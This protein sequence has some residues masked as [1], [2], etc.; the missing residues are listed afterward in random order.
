MGLADNFFA[1]GGHSLLA[2]Q[3]I[4]RV[5]RQLS[6]D[7]ALRAL[8]D[9]PE[10]GAFCAIAAA[11]CEQAE[12]AITLRDRA[13][14][15]PLSHAQQ[16][17]W[18]FWKI[19]PAS[20]AY[21]TPLAVRLNGALDLP[22]LQAAL[23][24]LLERHETLRSVFEEHDGTALQRVLPASGLPVV[25]EDWRACDQAGLEAYL[26]ECVEAPFDLRHG[27]LIRARL[28]RLGEA[29]HV[30]LLTLHHI[31]SDGWSMGVM[32]RECLAHYNAHREGTPI[33]IQPLAVQYADYASWQRERL[34]S[35]RQQAQIDYWKARL[36][37]DFSVLE[38]PA[39][40]LRPNVPSHRGARLDIRLPEH[41]TE[42]L[43]ALAVGANATLF[44]VFLAT[45]ALLLA[46]SSGRE[47]IN[48]GVPMTNRDRV[49]LE[50]LIGFFVN[51]VVVRTAVDPSC[52]FLDLL[53]Q[54]RDS[55]LGAQAHNDLPFDAL[56]EALQPQRS[57]SYNPLFQV[58]YNHLRDVGHKVDGSSAAGL[59]VTEL[60]LSEHT[61]QFDLSLNTLERSDG[62]LASFNYATD[63]FEASRIEALASQWLRVLEGIARSPSGA[64]GELEL[65]G[66][67]ALQQDARALNPAP[68]E[69]P[70]VAAHRQFEA[71]V[72]EAP[73]A[74]AL[75]VGTRSLTYSQ[76]NAH[77][78]RLAR[79]LIEHGIGPGQ[80]V[81]V[82]LPRDEHLVATL[83]AVFK[84][85]G[86][87]VPLDLAYPAERVAYMLEDSR[88]QV[89]V[90][91]S[92]ARAQLPRLASVQVLALDTLN[93]DGIAPHNLADSVAPAALAYCIYTSGSTG[94]PKGVM[95]EQRNLSALIGWAATV[96]DREQ[97]QGVLASTSICFDLSVWELFVTLALGGQV[98]LAENALQLPQLPARDQVRLINTVPSAIK[99]LLDARQ[100]PESIRTI[101]LAGEPLKQ[102]LVDALYAGTQAE[103]LYDLYG[104]S[105]D[106]TYS[107]FT[108]RTA[109][110]R[111]TI[112]RP[113]AGSWVH[114]LD[115]AGQR[116]AAGS[117]AE[118]CIGGVGLSR[119]YLG[120]P[121]LT[122]EKFLPDPFGPAPGQ[123]MY[124]TGDLARQDMAGELVYEGRIDHQV[125]V[126]GFRI[127]LGEIETRLQAFDGIAQ[128]V[129]LAVDG[130][131]VAYV[132]PT[133]EVAEATLRN[134][135]RAYLKGSLP[136]Y[137]VPAHFVVLSAL[138]LTPNGKLDRKALPA[139]QVQA[140]AEYLPPQTDIE[141]RL[142][143]FWAQ[144]LGVTRVGLTDNFFEL[145][146]HSLLATQVN[147]QAQAEYAI[148]LPLIELFQA[149]TLAA[150][151]QSV[152]ARIP[153]DTQDLDELRDFLTDLETV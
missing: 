37:D 152:A 106:T 6:L 76:L 24:A 119:G 27:P 31:V 96:Y 145:G 4:S 48:L 54:V 147:A 129:V 61:A 15:L 146:G 139:P 34:A 25:D 125:K 72:A 2:T 133:A 57:T 128:A 101:N 32:V 148:D 121:A 38:L 85:G 42:R 84:A 91:T 26:R 142:A 107:T 97:L 87:Y 149:P 116:V 50:G 69:Y 81:A 52:S 73:D 39:D 19:H 79:V 33:A 78:N 10:L 51:T 53:A 83:L 140:E 21:H 124:R 153:G 100:L 114:L 28:I 109:G 44:H 29:E 90:T 14:A 131:L 74:V 111:A 66:E 94:K 144:V 45:F 8:F 11:Q 80:K 5:R 60:E 46:R 112:G 17:Q 93:L 105:E 135:L 49:E 1:L 36:E 132:V 143:E 30:L 59:S 118:I 134:A 12:A 75:I 86:A 117:L 20:A 130:Q 64:V 77:A 82:A 23:D 151:A 16:R 127:E 56:V 18:L 43:R 55:A 99:A 136:A 62:L 150:Y 92:S 7:V 67:Q 95:I 89:L 9:A 68:L 102:E 13:Q 88:A 120:R 103:R 35:G 98:I 40:R 141:Q 126:R 63:L 110:G 108:L 3:L 71:R 22:A 104:P 113:L 58:M 138:P 122:A 65:Q 41:L 137:M 115:G 70:A 123:R 47:K